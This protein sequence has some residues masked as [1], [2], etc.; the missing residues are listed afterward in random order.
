MSKVTLKGF[1]LV[2]EADLDVVMQELPIHTELTRQEA[3]CLSF[4]VTQ[5]KAEPNRFDVHEEFRDRTAF[6]AHQTRVK[7]SHW[8]QV[9]CNVER[10]YEIS[11]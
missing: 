4:Q 11:E 2:P 6:E 10:H 9:T 7:N 8:G 5:S 1:I 3:G